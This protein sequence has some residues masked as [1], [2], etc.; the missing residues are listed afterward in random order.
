MTGETQETQEVVSLSL[1]Q[2][3][4]GE[5]IRCELKP[6][7]IEHLARQIQEAGR[8]HTALKVEPH[9]NGTYMIREGYYRYA[10]ALWL[11][12]HGV[13]ITLPCIIEPVTQSRL[14]RIKKQLSENRDRENLSPLEIGNTIHMMLEEG[15]PRAEILKHFSRPGGRGKTPTME[16][17][18][19]TAY[20]YYTRYRELP[21]EAQQMLH[22]G[23]L[24]V[25]VAN[26]FLDERDPKKRA[27][28]LA[29]AEEKRQERI[30]EDEARDQHLEKLKSE[31]TK[32]LA[33]LAKNQETV[34]VKTKEIGEL[35][36]EYAQQKTVSAAAFKEIGNLKGEQRKAAYAAYQAKEVVT[37]EAKS[38]L[39]AALKEKRKAQA[40]IRKTASTKRRVEIEER[41]QKKRRTL[42]EKDVKAA[43]HDH[44]GR[45]K[46]GAIDMRAAVKYWSEG[47]FPKV[48]AMAIIIQRTFDSFLTA[49]QARRELA[50]VTG[51]GK[52][53][54][55]RK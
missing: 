13:S 22:H 53:P 29:Y 26:R 19:E 35:Q 17:L 1:D 52:R 12:E 39:N 10:A 43:A 15:M 4:L 46:L 41:S 30:A 18:S 21:A 44:S 47:P 3:V 2:L 42:S 5:N 49:D 7:K 38:K 23:T 9:D 20:S 16:P 11:E 28:L 8:I 37:K 14:E 54:K 31:N 48:K 32:N 27:Q 36:K 45:I 40:D 55:R 24:G 33:T 34:K 51:E 6:Y 25:T 50:K